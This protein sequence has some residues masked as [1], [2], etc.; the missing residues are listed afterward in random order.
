MPE[1]VGCDDQYIKVA[2]HPD[3]L[4][5]GVMRGQCGVTQFARALCAEANDQVSAHIYIY[6]SLSAQ[7]L[8]SLSSQLGISIYSF[9]HR[10]IEITQI[11]SM[12]FCI[13]P[14]GDLSIGVSQTHTRLAPKVAICTLLS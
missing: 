6:I 12:F 10:S 14:S 5:G 1:H 13:M 4:H 8:V 2:V 11:H 7:V 9:M 3:E